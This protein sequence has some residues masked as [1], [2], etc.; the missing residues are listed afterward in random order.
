MYWVLEDKMSK[1]KLF[2][3][4][5]LL[6]LVITSLGCSKSVVEPEPTVE[7]PNLNEE[8]GGYQAIG[9]NPAFG[10]DELLA[11]AVESEEEYDD[12]F[13]ASAGMDSIINDSDAGH[14]HLRVVWGK[15][16]YDSTS[17]APTDWTGS[18]SITRGAEIIRRVIR[19]ERSTD[20]I[21]P[22][23]DR[24]LI[25]WV[26]Q[27][28]V[29]ND[30]IA[31]DIFVPRLRP[32][33]DTSRFIQVDSNGNEVVI[34]VVDTT[35]PSVEPVTVEFKT[36]P[37]SRI[38]KLEELVSLDTIVYLDDSNAVAFHAIKLDRFPCP[39]GFLAGAWGFTEDGRG[40]FR[41]VWIDKFGLV[42][43]YLKGH[44]G[45][46]DSGEQV[47]FGKWI[48]RTGRFEGFIRGHWGYCICPAADP[49]YPCRQAGYFNGSIYNVNRQEIG[50][51]G[52]QFYGANTVSNG[53]GGFFQ[54]R[55]KL[56]C[57][58]ELNADRNA[59]EGF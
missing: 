40:V 51:L 6:T 55:W 43:G 10:D 42:N 58:D 46:N 33:I 20:Y 45:K 16:R 52:G 13:L 23:K 27:T 57:D 31:V 9:E 38:F 4:L 36:A 2:H 49:S 21:V 25:E 47:F 30:G 17:T 3:L 44:F 1:Q 29:H 12:P 50:V 41:G 24:R 11:E 59:E 5:L 56:F 14:Y 28:T 22:R 18:L 54:G 7:D 35:W 53:R 34:I 15:L 37:Y 19:F 8:F 39:R 26:S 48:S 32:I